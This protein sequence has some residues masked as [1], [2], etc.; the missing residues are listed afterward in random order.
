[1]VEGDV[2]KVDTVVGERGVDASNGNSDVFA[3]HGSR[4]GAG[5]YCEILI[6]GIDT[7]GGVER[8]LLRADFDSSEASGRVAEISSLVSVFCSSNLLMIASQGFLPAA[9]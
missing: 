9:Q 3:D 5:L 1:M 7:D 4:C 2:P 6:S 8:A